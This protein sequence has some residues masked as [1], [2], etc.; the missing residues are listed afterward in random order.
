M[1]PRSATPKAG[2][3][4]VRQRRGNTKKSED[5]DDDEELFTSSAGWLDSFIILRALVFLIMSVVSLAQS[6]GNGKKEA[7]SDDVKTSGKGK[8]GSQEGAIQK[9]FSQEALEQAAA[10]QWKKNKIPI[11]LLIVGF[12]TS[13]LI[14]GGE[15]FNAHDDRPKE[16][17]EDFYGTLGVTRDADTSEVKRAYK[18][19]ARRWHP[20]KNLN[21]TTC[22]E[23][24]SKIAVA[25]ETLSDDKARASY[26]ETGGIATAELK[27]P[28]SVPLTQDNFDQLVTFSN[29]VWIVLVFKP[30]DGSCAQ[31]HPFW[32]SQIQKYGHLV[33]FGRVDIANDPAKWLPVKYRVLPTVL[34]FSRH[35]SSPEI[36]PITATHETPQVLMKFVLTSFPNIGLPLHVESM[37]LKKW[38]NGAGRRHKVL[39]ALPGKSEEERYK[40]HLVPRK[41]ASR[42]SEL[43][44]FR[45][46]ET[47]RLLSMSADEL[48]AEIRS[49][50]P[51]EKD[52]DKK[53][54][55]VFFSADGDPKPKGS[56]LIS[57]PANEDDMVLKLHEFAEMAAPPLTP[58]TA[59]LLCQSPSIR[60]VYC[61]VLVD[62]PDAATKKSMEELKESR[63]QHA[64]EVAEIREAGEV[65]SDEEDNFHVPAVR[66][67]TRSRGLQPSIQTCRAPK[68]N[69]I[70][71][72]LDGGNALLLDFDTGRIASLKGLTSFR[73]LYPQIAYEESLKWID[74]SFHSFLSLPDCDEGLLQHTVRSIRSASPLEFLVH[75][76][77]ALILLEAV[78]KALSEFSLKWGIGAGAVLLLV[79][80]RSPPFL[81]RF[82][83]FLPGQLFSPAL[84]NQ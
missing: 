3:G 39:L 27:S 40:S 62:P 29:D 83:G 61:L 8:N 2:S 76:A 58:Q 47:S 6:A 20:D 44:E 80:L 13:I 11:F 35:L 5:N 30:D 79:L 73:G 45:S 60:R 32:E 43:F 17:S 78:A 38:V 84:L 68:F 24:F 51:E 12:F 21:C 34:K 53:A 69:Q 33:R 10:E 9:K 52:K 16:I 81:R 75:L 26:D 74:E 19:L 7:A 41:M 48:P 15:S 36:F 56:A 28:R 14:M 64:K 65:T 82:C 4:E 42:W 59:D 63:E 71:Q 18:T 25:Y 77:T 22:Q 54:A 46:A 55:I 37:A 67:Y 70:E 31:F 1:P 50:L 57:W 66:L 23:T 49:L 72:A